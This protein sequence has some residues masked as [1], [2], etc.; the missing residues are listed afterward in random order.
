MINKKTLF[1]KLSKMLS[2]WKPV[3][4]TEFETRTLVFIGSWSQ[5]P[6]NSVKAEAT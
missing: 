3:W 4:R 1:T 2:S 6:S 5:K